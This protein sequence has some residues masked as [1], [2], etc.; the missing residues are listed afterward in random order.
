MRIRCAFHRVSNLHY[1]C[2]FEE[3]EVQKGNLPL[4]GCTKTM[5]CFRKALGVQKG[6]VYMEDLSCV[7]CITMYCLIKSC[8]TPVL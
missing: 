1:S 5:V 4:H 3:T 7:I 8:R 6:L 2:P